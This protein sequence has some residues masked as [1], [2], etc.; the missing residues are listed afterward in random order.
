MPEKGRRTN[1]SPTNTT[2]SLPVLQPLLQEGHMKAVKQATKLTCLR[3]VT[4][5]KVRFLCSGDHYSFILY[6]VFHMVLLG[7]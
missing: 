3:I 4:L 1:P 5:L 2:I 6:H 7:R